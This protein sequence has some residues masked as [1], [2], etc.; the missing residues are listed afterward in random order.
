MKILHTSDIHLRTC[1]DKRWEALEK[2]IEIAKREDIDLFVISGDL[3][4][5]DIDAEQLRPE[6][7]KIFSG[8]KFKIVLISGNHDSDSYRPG[9]FFG[10]DV[11]LIKDLSMPL[12]FKE[13]RIWGFP[14]QKM[15]ESE[16]LYKL[17]SIK[18]RI[19]N[20]KKNI[21][22]YH[23]E[24]LDDFFSR[25]D[26]GDEG[27]E[28]YMPV[29]LNYFKNLNIDYVL[30]GHFHA[31]FRI[32]EIEKDRYFVYPGSPI[33]ITK[34]EMGKRKVNI[35]N[36]G[37]TPKDYFLDTYY[38][39]EIKIKLDP[40]SEKDPMDIINRELNE[41]DSK[42]EVILKIGGYIN[43]K[44]LGMNEEKLI[45][46]IKKMS[47]KKCYE[48]HFNFRD[49][50]I[51]LEDDLFKSILKKLERNGYSKEKKREMI[52]L[53]ASSMMEALL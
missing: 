31:N 51:V 5:K 46:I 50:S 41:V 48:I 20:D 27:E 3:F 9:L 35:F 22:L 15:E 38:F 25:K 4:D 32:W 34:R 44:A 42:A 52:E 53:A 2:L 6:I 24:L 40:F 16:I 49:I 18:D 17:Y 30:A 28:R 1:E 10:D 39:K 11:L 29:K 23:G 13:V 7:R 8:N 21:L 36:V 12:D 47:Q 43:G 14:F 45:K 33:S 37:Q 26:M 19:K